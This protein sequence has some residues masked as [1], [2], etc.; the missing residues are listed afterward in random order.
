V[1][2]M[3]IRLAGP[4]YA[5][6][7]AQ[8][9]YARELLRRMESAP[10]VQAAGIS[11]WFFFSGAPAFPNDSSPDQ[12][13]VIRLNAASTGYLKAL[14]MRLVKGRWLADT[15]S[16]AAVL[17]N[18][19][20]VRQAFG[21][22]DPLGRSLSIPGPA[23]VVGVV[24]DLKYSQLD[25]E[26]PP[27]IYVRYQQVPSLRGTDVAV[28]A[29]GDAAA[30]A[31][32][33]RK[34]IAQIDPSQ[35]VYDVKTLDQAL[36]DTIAPRRFNLFLLGTFAAAALLLALVGIY[37]VIAY[38]VAARTRE[39]GVRMALGAQGRQVVRMVVLEGM[40]IA[41]AG[42]VAGLAAAWRLTG[43]MASLLYD[44][45]PDDPATFGAVGMALAVT[46][47]L[48]CWGPAVKAARVDPILALRHE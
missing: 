34:L 42:V 6:R 12:R 30:L 16:A 31:P 35:P 3:K 21:A 13:H 38:S 19:S 14:G 22:A 1:L 29:A 23:T 8:E 36:A 4:Q 32:A 47:L 25:A 39:I 43:L 33:M 10:G 24:A 18:E 37:G 9:V 28:R 5:T 7:P 15:D 17:L 45:K 48:A 27:E 20:M 40:A 44:V 11:N 41:L 26:P 2:V 46:A